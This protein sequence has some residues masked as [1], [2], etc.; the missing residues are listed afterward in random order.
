MEEEKLF[1]TF[2]IKNFI[3]KNRIGV[4][5]MTRMSS[6]KDSV[7]RQDVL[8]FLVTRAKNRRGDGLHGGHRY[9]LRERA[10]VSGT[11]AALN[12]AADRRLASGSG[13]DSKRRRCG[14]R[15]DVSLRKNGVA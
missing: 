8:D 13:G 1:S 15:A 3:L 4:A 9:R 5:P 14:G 11:G 2:K 7:P 6:K 12:P 10:G